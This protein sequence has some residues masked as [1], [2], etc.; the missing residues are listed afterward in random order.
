MSV[1]VL[2]SLPHVVQWK[3]LPKCQLLSARVYLFGLL[4]VSLAIGF[5]KMVHNHAACI[6]FKTACGYSGIATQR[7]EDISPK[8]F[9]PHKQINS[10]AVYN[11]C[12]PARVGD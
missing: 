12:E 1:T 6:I 2:V 9:D 4:K 5:S 3:A 7:R 10:T 8:L 11:G